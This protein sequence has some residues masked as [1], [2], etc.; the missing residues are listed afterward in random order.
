MPFQDKNT[1]ETVKSIYEKLT[2]ITLNSERQCFCIK[3]KN[4]AKTPALHTSIQYCNC[5]RGPSQGNQ[6]RN[7]NKRHPDFMFYSNTS[8]IDKLGFINT[9]NLYASK[10]SINKVKKE[11]THRIKEYI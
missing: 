6:T 4:K 11:T 10:D 7:R 3:I 8:K 9:K 2:N 5:I 1:Q